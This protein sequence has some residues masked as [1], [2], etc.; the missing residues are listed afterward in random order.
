MNQTI[1]LADWRDGGTQLSPSAKARLRESTLQNGQN[2]SGTW[3]L[4]A[5]DQSSL[6]EQRKLALVEYLERLGLPYSFDAI[7]VTPIRNS[8]RSDGIEQAN[9]NARR[10]AGL[11]NATGPGGRQ[12]AYSGGLQGGMRTGY[13]PF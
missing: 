6:D 13:S 12:D 11:G 8:L 5:S 4:E 9:Q 1:Y 3:Y 7:L 10:G 2:V